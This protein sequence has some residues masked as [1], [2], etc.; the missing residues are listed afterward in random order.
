MENL[1]WRCGARIVA[2]LDMIFQVL[3]LIWLIVVA[4]LLTIHPEHI[5]ITVRDRLLESP[6]VNPSVKNESISD[7]DLN[8]NTTSSATSDVELITFDADQN[9]DSDVDKKIDD[10]IYYALMIIWVSMAVSVIVTVIKLWVAVLLI[11]ATERD[12][13]TKKSLKNT[14]TWL[15]VSVIM[16]VV[17][18]AKYTLT[19]DFITLGITLILRLI[20]LFFVYIFMEEV[21]HVVATTK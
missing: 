13:E 8:L 7:Y 11:H 12:A 16:L 6:S 3:C 5:K 2:W 1:K 21:R 20:F 14:R 10:A 15:I 17:S 18:T 19:L 4:T 9:S